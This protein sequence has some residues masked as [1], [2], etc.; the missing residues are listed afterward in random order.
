MQV[1]LPMTTSSWWRTSRL[2]MR[3]SLVCITLT[4][5]ACSDEA[6]KPESAVASS[7]GAV[8]DTLASIGGQPITMKDVRD[9]LG[10][11]LDRLD[12]QY[13]QARSRMLD[14]ALQSVLAE[15]VL[16]MAAKKEGKSIQEMLAAELGSSL[17]PTGVEVA[18]WYQDNQL[19]VGGRSLDQ[20]RP[21]IVD[22]LRQQR[23][24]EAAGK[25]QQRLNDEL[26][27]KVL[28]EPYRLTFN[29]TGA[30]TLGSPDAAVTLVEFS[31][32]QCPYCKGFAPTLHQVAK[33]FG[34]KVLIVYRQYPIASLHPNAQKAAE[35]SLCANEQG[36]FW[37]LHDLMFSEQDRLDVANLKEK[38]RRLGMNQKTFDNCL[39]SGRYV[40]Q[41]ERDQLEG[42]KI[43]F[44]GTPSVFVNGMEVKGGAVPFEV[45]RAAIQR[46]LLRAD[47]SK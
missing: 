17:E 34:D 11:S 4:S 5:G 28:Y 3:L 8:P 42:T 19:R 39:D 2:F 43:G 7:S 36:K 31:D 44:A 6:A 29:N 20:I 22:F 12:I 9:R 13:Q 10:P 18:A 1:G 40:E 38:A 32:F 14:S 25:L 45:V 15:R 33:E 16:D 24:H 47:R 37:E 35:A 23:L 21:Q 30:P 41:I 27:V 46:E 26:S